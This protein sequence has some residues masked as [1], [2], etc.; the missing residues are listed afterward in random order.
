MSHRF[1]GRPLGAAAVTFVLA[2]STALLPAPAAA[3]AVVAESLAPRS[4]P[5]PAPPGAPDSLTLRPPFSSE[6]PPPRSP[7]RS[8][9]PPASPEELSTPRGAVAPPERAWEKP[10]P[11]P[12]PAVH[13]VGFIGYDLGGAT[14][15]RQPLSDGST[16]SISA[17]QGF[18]ASLGVAFLKVLDG[19]LATQATIGIQGWSIDASDGSVQWL[20]F[21]L[22]VMEF[23]YVDPFRLGA[24]LSYLMNPHSW[25]TGVVKGR[26]EVTRNFNSSLGLALEADWVSTR[27]GARRAR[28]TFGARYTWQKLQ[29]RSG[30]PLIDASSVAFLLGYTG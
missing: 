8:P 10:P 19:R 6:P 15:V 23:V 22:D 4:A 9:P 7:P 26:P 5:R 29:D 2:A 27:V 17:R 20:A 14:L 1:A 3:E 30:G 25:G 16:P 21:P 12:E 24:G 18:D 13:F 11:V 28:A